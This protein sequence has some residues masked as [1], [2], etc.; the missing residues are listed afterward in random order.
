MGIHLLVFTMIG[1]KTS[2]WRLLIIFL[3]GFALFIA[4]WIAAKV[5]FKRHPKD[6][7]ALLEMFQIDKPRKK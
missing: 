6:K 7:K 3:I 1:V 5:Y 4:L 2:S